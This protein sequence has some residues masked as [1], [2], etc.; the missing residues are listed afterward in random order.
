[1]SH[2]CGSDPPSPYF[3]AQLACLHPLADDDPC[4][5]CPRCRSYS[6][7]FAL[8]GALYAFNECVI[9]K[10]RAKHDKTNPAVAGCATGAMLAYTGGWRKSY[11]GLTEMPDKTSLSIP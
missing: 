8:F 6:K 1:M 5:L 7:A 3:Y 9:E 11:R 4:C 2:W 10:F